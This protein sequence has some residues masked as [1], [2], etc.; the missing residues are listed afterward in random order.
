MHLIN[1][2]CTRRMNGR[3]EMTCARV[4]YERIRTRCSRVDGGK[5]QQKNLE[6]QGIHIRIGP[7]H[8]SS[9]IDC[10]RQA[11]NMNQACVVDSWPDPERNVYI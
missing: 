11:E 4:S 1:K 7:F 9:D 3:S 10:I 5:Q 2:L 6:I 8:L